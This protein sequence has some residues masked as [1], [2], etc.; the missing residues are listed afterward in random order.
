ML[1]SPSII[2]DQAGSFQNQQALNQLSTE[3][4]Q[5]ENPRAVNF[6]MTHPCPSQTSQSL[7]FIPRNIPC[8][9]GTAE[10]VCPNP[11]TSTAECSL[12]V[13]RPSPEILWGATQAVLAALALLLHVT[14]KGLRGPSPATSVPPKGFQMGKKAELLCL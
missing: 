2:A 5:Q 14:T 8:S 4:K 13:S 11:W 7:W 12:L 9:Q 3:L 6:H 1:P 10:F